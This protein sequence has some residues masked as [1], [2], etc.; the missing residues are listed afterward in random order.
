MLD[1]PHMFPY[2]IDFF[3]SGHIENTQ[4]GEVLGTNDRNLNHGKNR[5]GNTTGV[6]T[7]VAKHVLEK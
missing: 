6:V 4:G 1:F 2:D 3:L 7:K 5:R